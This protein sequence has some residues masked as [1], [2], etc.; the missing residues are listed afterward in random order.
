DT[1]TTVTSSANPAAAGQQITLTATVSAVAPGAGTPG[2][3][4]TFKEG[5]TTLGTGTLNSSGQ[6]TF[7]ASSLSSGAHSITA[8]FG[9]NDSFNA[10]T[11]AALAQSVNAVMADLEITQ[12]PA[13]NVVSG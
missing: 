12:A 11:S 6:A 8:E 5:A 1:S 9:G 3:T 7:T 10:S 2:G 13:F 4:V